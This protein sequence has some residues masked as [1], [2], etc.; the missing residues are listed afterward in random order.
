MLCYKQTVVYCMLNTTCFNT[1]EYIPCEGFYHDMLCCMLDIA[2]CTL[3]SVF[4]D[5]CYACHY[6]IPKLGAAHFIMLVLDHTLCGKIH[7]AYSILRVQNTLC[8]TCCT[9]F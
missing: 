4:Y 3:Y 8:I 6:R 7:D 2:Y 9:L 5:E 1:I